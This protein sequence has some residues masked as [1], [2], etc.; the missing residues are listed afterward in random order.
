ML[1]HY[2]HHAEQLKERDDYI[3]AADLVELEEELNALKRSSGEA[4]PQRGLA[5]GMDA[6]LL[7]GKP[8]KVNRKTYIRLAALC[9]WFTGLHRFYA[10]QKLTGAMYLMFCW[11]GIP[12]AMTI[13]DLMMVLP[14]QADEHG[15]ISL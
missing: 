3:N 11:T 5:R 8:H 13:M 2:E 15:I 1:W 9:G 14:K 7:R 12:F 10:G 4:R 6:L